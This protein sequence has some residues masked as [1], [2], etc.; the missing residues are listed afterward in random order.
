MA[1]RLCYVFVLM[2]AACLNLAAATSQVVS[3]SLVRSFPKDEL[4][5]FFKA[6]HIPKL[7]LPVIDGIDVYEVIYTTLYADSSE[8]KASGL[9]YV[10]HAKFKELPLMIYDHGT[11]ICRERSNSFTGEQSICLA[12]AT[13]GYIVIAPDYVGMGSGERDQLYLDAFTESHASVDM[14]IA[15]THLLPM[16]DAKVSD[17]LFVTGYSQ[18]GHAAMATTRLLQTEH[19]DRFRVTAASPMSGPYDLESMVYDGRN[20]SYDYPV[21]LMMLLRTYYIDQGNVGALANALIE[22]Y[23]KTIPPLMD[24]EY[25]FDQIN[26]NLPD[27]VFKVL[28]TAFY[29]DYDT[30][31]KS[32]FKAFLRKNNVYDWRPEMPMQLCYCDRDE[33]VTYKNS[34]TAY[35][36][37]KKNGA[38]KVELWRSGKKFGHVHCALFS[39]IYTK[40]YFDGFMKGRPGSHGPRF[41]RMLVNIGKLAVP[42]R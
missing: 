40:M 16:L 28:A 9:L 37:M 8:V 4:S 29:T 19:A 1:L 30:N 33:E 14:L 22:P 26:D 15:S 5:A 7:I 2:F 18:G 21:F 32:N 25:T 27:T 39:V 11:T 20:G 35:E 24:G 12:F 31:P 6:H 13:D 10:P 34:I 3:Y 23:C 42:A 38:Q 36:T 41:V 17:K